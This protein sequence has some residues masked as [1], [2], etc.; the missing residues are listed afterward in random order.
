MKKLI[1]QHAVKQFQTENETKANYA[2][3]VIRTIKDMMYRYFTKHKTY[4]YVDVLSHIVMNYNNRPHRSIDQMHPAN[5][6]PENEAD[7]WK[8]QYLINN[9]HNE[10]NDNRSNIKI[11]DHVRITHTKKT[12]QRTYDEKWTRELFVIVDTQLQAG[13]WIYKLKDFAGEEVSGSFYSSELQKVNTNNTSVWEIEK[14]S[15]IEERVKQEK[16]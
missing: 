10:I 9:N 8:K 6:T 7:L 2:E 12:F 16:Y 4:R 14:R 1:A 3:R 15:A 11:G 5:V 13:I